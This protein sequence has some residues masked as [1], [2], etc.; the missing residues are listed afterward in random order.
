MKIILVSHGKLAKGMK[1]TIDLIIG[2]QDNLFAYDAYSN[3]AND[4]SF[5]LKIKELVKKNKNDQFI[6]VTDILG[7]SVNNEMFQLLKTYKNIDLLTGMNLPLI[8]TLVTKSENLL[9]KKVIK[10]A[11]NEG[12]KGVLSVNELMTKSSKENLL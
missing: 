12:K 5:A 3:S 7:G 2:K 1:D 10:E 8:I 6:I 11:I 9:N 4:N